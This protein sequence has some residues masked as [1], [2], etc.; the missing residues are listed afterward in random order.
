MHN[1]GPN[2]KIQNQWKICQELD[3]MHNVKNRSCWI[4]KFLDTHEI[5]DPLP[6][7]GKIS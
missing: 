4:H 1:E 6:G 5:L 7:A 2:K 3:N